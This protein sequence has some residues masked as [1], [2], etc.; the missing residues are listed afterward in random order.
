MESIHG[1]SHWR[2][3]EATAAYLC[4]LEEQDEIIPR[5]FA[6]FHDFLRVNDDFDPE[7]G[8]RAA[9]LLRSNRKR[10]PELSDQELETLA[11]A[12]EGHTWEQMSDDPIVGI[13]WDS[14]RLDL[15]R[16]GIVPHPKFF[17]SPSGKRIAQNICDLSDY[18]ELDRARLTFDAVADRLQLA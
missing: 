6:L 17:S 15:G 3:V 5:M 14:D 4:R 1:P 13:C 9:Q 8:P 7:H 16:F 11:Y 2:N 12:C 18:A 10:F